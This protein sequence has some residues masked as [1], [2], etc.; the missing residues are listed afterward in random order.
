MEILTRRIFSVYG[1]KAC[2][3]K[4]K[5]DEIKFLGHMSH[6]GLSFMTPDGQG[7]LVFSMEMHF[8]GGDLFYAL[9]YVN[10]KQASKYKVMIIK[11][12]STK[13]INLTTP[14]AGVLVLGHGHIGQIVRNALFLQKSSSLLFFSRKINIKRQMP[15][16]HNLLRLLDR[17]YNVLSLKGRFNV[18]V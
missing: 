9:P 16:L 4:E 13:I 18:E 5:K 7:F 1:H 12:G 3:E 2:T 11:E 17:S 8:L 15:V 6:S 10:L 14:G